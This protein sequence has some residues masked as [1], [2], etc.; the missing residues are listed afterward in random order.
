MDFFQAFVLAIIQ[1]VVEWLPISSK[2]M[3]TLAGH[4][5]FGLDYQTAFATALWLHGGP[6]IA[7]LVYFRKDIISI[8]QSIYTKGSNKELLIFLLIASALTALIGIPLVL[9]T[10]NLTLPP[11]LFTVFIGLFLVAV[12]FIRKSQK[13]DGAKQNITLVDGI[14]AGIAQG[15][16][17]VPGLSR[18]GM[19]TA[20][21]LGQKFSL[22]DALKLSFLMS[23]PA[24]IGVEILLP[25]IK[26][27]G[28]AFVI[29][30]P[31]I[32]GSIAAGIMAFITIS[33]LLK[34]AEKTDFFKATL[35]LGIL[36]IILGLALLL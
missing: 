1:G 14:I 33:V 10:L 22:K 18:S 21:L 12:A 15:L 6:L 26:L 34:Y 8:I 16:A 25:I 19:T 31:L 5:L 9:L 4:F 24:I 3:V 23:I 28:G 13:A 29:T 32:A 30:L 36:T 35:G 27:K 11:W 17:G 20:A 2:A 7:E